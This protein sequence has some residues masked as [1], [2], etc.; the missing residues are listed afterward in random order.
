M[1]GSWT[2][3]TIY[4]PEVPFKIQSPQ[5]VYDGIEFAFGMRD[6]K[7]ISTREPIQTLSHAWIQL[8]LFLP[9]FVECVKGPI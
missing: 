9:L 1:Q 3:P 4:L 2:L 8:Q 5:P 7:D 6:E